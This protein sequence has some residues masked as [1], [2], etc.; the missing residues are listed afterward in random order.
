MSATAIRLPFS[1]SDGLARAG[2]HVAL[3][4]RKSQD[5]AVMFV[6][7]H[8]VERLC[9]AVG[10]TQAGRVLD[11]FYDELGAMA[12]DNDAIER[13]GDRKFAVLLHGLRNRGH[14]SLA[15]QKVQRISQSIASAHVERRP[16]KVSIGVVLCPEQGT[17]EHE[18]MRFAEIAALDCRRRSESVSFYEASSAY[19]LFMDWGLEDRLDKAL[20]SGDLE[21]RF[22]P[23][24]CCEAGTVT[25]AEALMRWHEPEIGDISPEVFI[26]LAES[27]GQIGRLT[28]F[29]VQQACRYLSTWQ[30]AFPE[31]TIAVNL[32]PGLIQNLEILDV[33][34]SAT[35][36]W[37]VRPG[38]LTLEVTENALIADREASHEVLTRLRD[39]GTRVSID[40]F[41]TG[42]SS[43][44]YL[45][46]IPADELKI[47]RSFVMGMLTDA[48]DRKIVEHSI[49]IAKS[50]GLSVVAEGVENAET[51][52]AL[53]SLD[54][55]IAQGFHVCKPVTADEFE[56]FCRSRGRETWQ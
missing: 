10:H 8:G 43:L 16:L 26:E 41:G 4:I 44:A 55:D 15:A 32:A 45:K 36:I 29:A 54:C 21:L 3:A 18:I 48:G 27:T 40:D 49:G 13:I 35:S 53:R 56:A 31:L 17:D 38:G 50:F 37:G 7:V 11:E 9:A 14:A 23:Q 33:L 6:Y 1:Q 25:S 2:R 5:L 52:E 42:Y 30:E 34:K 20:E 28:D 22:Q 19:E 12:R 47:D 24:V 51:L 39:F 46:E